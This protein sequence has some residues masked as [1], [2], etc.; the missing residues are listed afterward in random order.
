MHQVVINFCNNRMTC[1][2]ASPNAVMRN[3]T[4]GSSDRLESHLNPSREQF[5]DYI[6]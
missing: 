6:L 5:V 4:L 3:I 1:S 2:A